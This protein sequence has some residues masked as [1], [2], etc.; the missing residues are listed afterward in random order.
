MDLRCGNI[1]IDDEF[2][3]QGI[4]DWEWATTVP[5]QPFTSPA[6]M[7]G[8]DPDRRIYA[9]DISS[10][11]HKVLQAKLTL[12]L[13]HIL[14][15]PTDL[16]RVY[17]RFICPSK[18]DTGEGASRSYRQDKTLNLAVQEWVDLSKRYT[19]YLQDNVLYVADELSPMELKLMEMIRIHQEKYGPPKVAKFQDQAKL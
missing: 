15:R 1:L 2:Q 10:Q 6:W 14:H 16:A 3:I 9:D 4:I 11:F 19:K 13:V 17:Y 7:T 5:Q 8:H 18:K 12:P